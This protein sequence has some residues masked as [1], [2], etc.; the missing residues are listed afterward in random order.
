[1][2]IL[3]LFDAKQN[4]ALVEDK[5]ITE[6]KNDLYNLVVFNTDIK[7]I[8][9]IKTIDQTLIFSIKFKTDE[10]YNYSYNFNTFT[11]IGGRVDIMSKLEKY[12]DYY[13]FEEFITYLKLSN[14]QFINY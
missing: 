14:I 9:F 4:L 2:N 8:T 7:T 5:L 12:F 3:E 11:L 13:T 10:L 1:M 6:F